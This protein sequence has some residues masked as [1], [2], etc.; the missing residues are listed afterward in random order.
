MR[1]K[2]PTRPPI[3]AAVPMPERA[4]RS[5]PSPTR[6][7][8][9]APL[10]PPPRPAR[11]TAIPPIPAIPAIPP[12]PTI[13][14]I[15]PIPPIASAPRAET[16]RTDPEGRAETSHE[17]DPATA[18]S[19]P[20]E[21]GD[22]TSQTDVSVG[23]PSPEEDEIDAAVANAGAGDTGIDG[24]EG[25]G[26]SGD[27]MDT[28]PSGEPVATAPPR[29]AAAEANPRAAATSDVALAFQT[30]LLVPEQRPVTPAA[31]APPTSPVVRERPIPKL[32]ISTAPD[33]LPPPTDDKQAIGPSPACPQCEAPM[34]WVEEHLRF[35]CKSCRMYF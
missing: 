1:G 35:Y 30:T 26:R 18:S 33:S 13:P 8:P 9:S 20:L 17:V 5:A 31:I 3:K 24:A 23:V 21:V 28:S 7:P 22:Y 34:V 32:P 27:V 11:A 16:D 4:T 25:D 6:P 12:I 29:H 2:E 15:P 14:A 10:I 19:V